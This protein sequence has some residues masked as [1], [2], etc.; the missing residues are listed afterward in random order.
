MCHG[1]SAVGAKWLARWGEEG[2]GASGLHLPLAQDVDYN[3]GAHFAP[4]QSCRLV[5]A[6]TVDVHAVD[7]D[8]HICATSDAAADTSFASSTYRRQQVRRYRQPRHQDELHASQTIVVAKEMFSEKSSANVLSLTA[9]LPK[10]SKLRQ[11]PIPA[12]DTGEG[13]CGVINVVLW[14]VE[15]TE[16][17]V[18]DW[19]MCEKDVI[20]GS[21]E[22]CFIDD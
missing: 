12:R 21:T 10:L 4:D 2:G 14:A 9:N 6:H 15:L 17:F 16:N 19:D 13:V 3:V 1:K 11:M 5:H 18:S 7:S 8:N 22:R 20:E